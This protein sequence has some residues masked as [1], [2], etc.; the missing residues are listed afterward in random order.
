MFRILLGSVSLLSLLLGGAAFAATSHSQR[1]WHNLVWRT[2]SAAEAE[3]AHASLGS[4]WREYR[5]CGRVP[6][7]RPGRPIAFS[8]APQ[9]GPGALETSAVT[10]EYASLVLADG[11]LEYRWYPQT[12][13]PFS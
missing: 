4:I 2:D 5:V 1:T 8:D 10:R 9:R 12:L 3:G 6:G 11:R 7:Q 13:S